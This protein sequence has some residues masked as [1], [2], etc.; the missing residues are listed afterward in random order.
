VSNI[1]FLPPTDKV[2]WKLHDACAA[3]PELPPAGLAKLADDIAANGLLEPVTLTPDGQLLDGRNRALACVMA[4]V[5]LKTVTYDG[6]PVLYSLSRN[7]H[8]RHMT[9]DQ[10]AMAVAKMTMRPLGANQHEGGSGELPSIAQSAAAAG[11]PKTAVKSAKVVRL[12]GTPEEIKRVETGAVPLRK[13]ADQVR[14][15]KRSPA[16]DKGAPPA[17]HD[18]IDAVAREIIS[19]TSD[20]KWRSLSRVASAVNFAPSAVKDALRCLGPDCVETQKSGIEIEYRIHDSNQPPAKASDLESQ[21]AAANIR[22]ADL[23]ASLAAANAE[24]TELKDL[25]DAATAPA[26]TLHQDKKKA[27]PP[28]QSKIKGAN[29]SA[30]S[31]AVA[32]N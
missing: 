7:Q 24:I 14:A 19:K 26:A 2:P 1:S 4:G 10:I 9:T 23:E 30:A 3:W 5:E 22:V 28:S 20:G 27:A 32:A 15:R 11:I 16:S 21:L 31:A 25:L 18:P 8:R 6:N 12:H 17:N 13:T 29:K